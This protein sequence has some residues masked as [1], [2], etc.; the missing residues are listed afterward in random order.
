MFWRILPKR[1]WL[2][3]L[4]SMVGLGVAFYFLLSLRAKSQV[5][6][7]ILAQG[8]TLVRA[9]ASNITS[10]FQLFGESV[11]L[12]AQLRSMGRRDATTLQDLD[13]FVE[14][15]GSSGLIGGIVLV[16]KDGVVRLNSNVLK[17]RDVGASL[18]DR[19]YFV[20]AK[21]QSEEGEYFV[22]QPVISRLE[23]SKGQVIVPVTSPVYQNDVFVGV[24]VASV[25]LQPLVQRY[26]ELMK[27]TDETDVHLLTKNGD[28]LYDSDT[29]DNVGTN[30]FTPLDPESFSSQTR[31]KSSNRDGRDL[32]GVNHLKADTVARILSTT[33]EGTLKTREHLIAIAPVTL[34]D[35]TWIILMT[36]PVQ[37][38]VNLT[39]PIYLRQL[40]IFLLVSLNTLLVGVV[41]I[42]GYQKRL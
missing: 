35:Q 32:T 26:L 23:A 30:T 8:A 40:A 31:D 7:R 12:R 2:V 10:F 39:T 34:S 21:N 25:K 9:E 16:D 33:G 20:W 3:W 29:P 13:A 28:L 15:W 19:D 6:Q 41:A 4:V 17:T 14:Q 36:T 38:V 11:A 42:R 18:A 1:M 27:V 22:G 37:T 24:L 5:T